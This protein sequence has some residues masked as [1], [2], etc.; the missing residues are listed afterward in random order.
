MKK[1]FI[2]PPGSLVA[3][4]TWGVTT[5]VEYVMSFFWKELPPTPDWTL[6]AARVNTMEERRSAEKKDFFMMVK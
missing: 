2:G 1:D 6:P 4:G 5:S 3:H